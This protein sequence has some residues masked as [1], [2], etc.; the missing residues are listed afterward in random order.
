MHWT[1]TLRVGGTGYPVIF[2]VDLGR[3]MSCPNSSKPLF[4]LLF[5]GFLGLG[6]GKL[7]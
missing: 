3:F 6:V 7:S 1:A 2:Q 4:Y 5:I